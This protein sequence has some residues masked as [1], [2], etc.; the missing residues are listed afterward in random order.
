[1]MRRLNISAIAALLLIVGCSQDDIVNEVGLQVTL[2][3]ANTYL[4]GEPVNFNI[5]GDVD[6]IV[7]FSGEEGHEFRYRDRNSFPVEEVTSLTLDMRYLASWGTEGGLDVYVSNTF[8]GLDGH[9]AEKD[10]QTIRDMSASGMEGWT[11]LDYVEGASELWT[12]QRYD[13][14]PFIED[15]TIAFHWHPFT[16]NFTRAQRSYNLIGE[17]TH[18]IEGMPDSKTELRS[19]PFVS[20]FMNEEETD[21]YMHDHRGDTTSIATVCFEDTRYDIFFRGCNQYFLPYE[22]DSW[23]ISKPHTFNDVPT[24]TGVPIKNLTTELRRYSYVFEEPGTYTVTFLGANSNFQG[25][26]RRE[27]SFTVNILDHP[28]FR[29]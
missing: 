17:F 11:K 10:R 18:T 23:V 26:S 27:R 28:L 9:D 19:L 29:D 7:F 13:L 22:L 25:E 15:F 14:T 12:S 21:P 2:D 24:D 8:P 4:A 3:P 6:F 20:V 1:M 16:Y 5:S